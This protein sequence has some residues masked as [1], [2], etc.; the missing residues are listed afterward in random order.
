MVCGNRP[1][2]IV[3]NG[4]SHGNASIIE[5]SIEVEIS[6]WSMPQRTGYYNTRNL[7]KNVV[8]NDALSV[9]EKIN[10][11]IDLLLAYSPSNQVY[12]ERQMNITMKQGNFNGNL[13][14]FCGCGKV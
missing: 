8:L 13:G 3:K 10:Q 14:D 2:T 1:V 5:Y 9:S 6:Y 7:I 11:I 4:C 12:R